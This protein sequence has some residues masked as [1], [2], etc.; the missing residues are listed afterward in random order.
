MLEEQDPQVELLD[1]VSRQRFLRA[2]GEELD[3]EPHVVIQP[4]AIVRLF[5]LL[6]DIVDNNTLL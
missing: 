3:G 2:R 5:K 6:E 1:K 4:E